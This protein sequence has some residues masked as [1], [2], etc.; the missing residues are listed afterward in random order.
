[1]YLRNPK[2]EEAPLQ[3]ELMLFNPE[4][5]QFYLLNATMAFIWQRCN[6]ERPMGAL[7]DEMAA[8]FEGVD[9]TTAASEIQHAFD[10][11][12][13]LGLLIDGAQQTR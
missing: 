9:S 6:L 10:E 4:S 7:I 2:V 3:Q 1:M 13:R 11:M 12:V 8:A 5:S